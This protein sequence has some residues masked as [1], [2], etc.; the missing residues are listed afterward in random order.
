[1]KLTKNNFLED[2]VYVII[3]NGLV[4]LSSIITGLI[5]PKL[6]GVT[7]Y[8]Y[9]K[10]FSLYVGYA[11]LLHF[12][13]VDGI[14]LSYANKNYN[15]LNKEKFR[16]KT[17]FFIYM[18][19]VISLTV[20]FMA[21]ILL[22]GG[23]YQFIFFMIGLDAIAMN[24]TSYYQYVSQCTMRFKELSFRKVLQAI[25]RIIAI[26]IL[27]ILYKNGTILEIT[28]HIYIVI[29]VMIDIILTVWYIYTYRD[30]TFGKREKISYGYKDLIFYFKSGIILTI[31]YQ[32]TNL[33]YSLDRQFVSIFFETN[34][35]ANYSFAYSLISIVTTVIGAVSLV[36]F[37]QLK[38]RSK[39]KIIENFSDSMALI[40]ILCF[41]ALV[42]Y[43]PLC[44]FIKWFLPDYITSLT[45]FRILFPGLAISSCIN[46]IIFTYYKVLDKN[47]LY[48]RI[49]LG[50][51]VLSAIFNILAYYYFKTTSAISIASIFVLILWYLSGEYYYIK[52]YKV[53]WKR[54]FI[55]I[56]LMMSGF[57]CITTFI[58]NDWLGI[59][60]YA[61]LFIGITYLIYKK[62][63][64]KNL[65]R[66]K[67][68]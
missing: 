53:K 40:S 47:T 6:L 39:E 23:V 63:I 59:F 49:S 4:L 20:I 48:F 24:V 18:Q 10:I 14:L 28:C 19:M 21:S 30:I 35:Y 25:L 57:Y 33:I 62:L 31:A 64:M 67:N 13:F 50:I 38:R 37:P 60:I 8:G 45:Y 2:L 16:L 15:E 17:R 58:V 11:A 55:Y 12:G 36:L 42:G 7:N 68:K 22:K 56:L 52:T 3:S 32:V 66:F 65:Q 41:A 51:L 9:Y 44:M 46:T 43:Y 54:N 61:I 26:G 1:M 5:V 27:L 34:I 29:W